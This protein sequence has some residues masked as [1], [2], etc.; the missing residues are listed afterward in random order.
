MGSEQ[1]I[2][3]GPPAL[4]CSYCPTGNTP[5]VVKV[6]S[7][8]PAAPASATAARA[9]VRD[10]AARLRLDGSTTW[11]L[12]LATTEAIANAVEHGEPCDRRGIFLRLEALNGTFEVEVRDCGGC[13]P[14]EARSAKPEEQGGRGMPIIAA[15]MDR[16]E[17]VPS[18]GLTRVRFEKRVTATA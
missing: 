3:P 1:A 9:L 12:M 11:E 18:T 8:L 6:E 16:L 14:A 5:N 2:R 4:T 17:I 10:A 13:Y 15:I 7:W